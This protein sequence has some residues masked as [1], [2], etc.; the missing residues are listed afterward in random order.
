MRNYAINPDSRM[1]AYQQLARLIRG[2]IKSGALPAGSRLPTVRQLADSMGLA[3]GTIKHAYDEL[4]AMGA[5][6]MTRGRGS[7]VKKL[8]ESDQSRKDRAMKAIDGLLDQLGALDFTLG[9]VSIFFELKLRERSAEETEIKVAFVE[10]DPETLRQVTE[11]LKGQ[12][13]GLEGLR[14]Y[15]CPLRDA[16]ANPYKLGEEMELILT[17]AGHIPALRAAVPE[18]EKLLP[19]ALTLGEASLPG[20]AALW[21]YLA[22]SGESPAAD[23]SADGR[24]D[25]GILSASPAFGARLAQSLGKIVPALRPGPACLLSDR[26]ALPAWLAEKR[27]ILLPEGHE[28]FCRGEA[29]EWL[30]SAGKTARLARFGYRIDDGSLLSLTR[31]VEDLRERNGYAAS[32]RPLPPR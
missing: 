13:G 14:V 26:S 7:F 16:L 28:A 6:E 32:A 19:V 24:R 27:L 22:A 3:R 2:D 25:A 18:K 17:T 29:L 11:G 12:G 31:R 15:P 23:S 30:A 8:T 9:E 1:P 4:E 10:E 21:E 20:L 5:I